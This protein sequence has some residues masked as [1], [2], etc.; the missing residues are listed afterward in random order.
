MTR[1]APNLRDMTVDQ[2]IELRESIDSLLK[3]AKQELQ[4]R[5]AQLEGF[6]GAGRDSDRRGRGRP[7]K[8]AGAPPKFRGPGGETWAGRG[9]RP[10]WLR[11]LLEAGHSLEEFAI[12]EVAAIR[13]KA[14]V[15]RSGGRKKT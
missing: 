12:G 1:S 10:R 13:K 4:D 3:S 6:A 2:L 7:P 9:A 8:G 15:K 5:L 11:A 14:S